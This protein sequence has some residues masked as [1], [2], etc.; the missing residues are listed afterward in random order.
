MNWRRLLLPGPENDYTPHLLQRA[1]MVFM[2][3]LVLLSFAATNLQALLWQSSDWL[4]GT[5][6]PAVVVNLTNEQRAGQAAAPL[7]RNTLLDEAARLKAEHMAN[8]GYF[9]HYSPEG[10]S[11]WYWFEQ[12]NYTYAH[13]GENLAIHFTDSSAVVDAWMKSPT[14]RAN[15][16]NNTYTEIGVGTAKGIYDGYSTV[17]VVQL[18]GT[19]AAPVVAAVAPTP[20]PAPVVVP[21]VAVALPAPEPA[22]VVSEAVEETPVVEPVRQPEP[23]TAEPS[24]EEVLGSTEEMVI[25]EVVPAPIEVA[26]VVTDASQTSVFSTHFATSSGL[27]PA[28]VGS[29]SGTT[30]DTYS[31]AEIAA[32]QPS[33]ILQAVYLGLG[34][35]VATLLLLSIIIGIHH[36]R[37]LQVVYGVGL[38]LLM[39]GLFYIHVAL[40][41]SVVIAATPDVVELFE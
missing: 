7:V 36:T 37:P 28:A 20:T 3:V 30:A 15:I 34:M 24:P 33:T 22:P 38:L 17:F 5:V 11:P 29:V 21:P 13:A 6:L 2:S 39:S 18:F 40:T 10:V 26:E 23:V 25:E 31:F 19:P 4:V 9:A 14:H 16:V 12:V 41:T 1:A 35:L 8:N 27:E 32:T